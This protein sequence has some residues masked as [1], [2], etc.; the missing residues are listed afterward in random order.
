MG[1]YR[2]RGEENMKNRVPEREENRT[3]LQDILP[4]GTLMYYQDLYF[5]VLFRCLN[6]RNDIQH[7]FQFL[8][9]HDLRLHA[10]LH[11]VRKVPQ[12]IVVSV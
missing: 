2:C 6:Q 1:K 5:S 8:R 7:I 11:A 12:F 10:L 3:F 9:F 4:S